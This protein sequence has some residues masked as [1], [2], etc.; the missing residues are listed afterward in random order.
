MVD[1]APTGHTLRLLAMPATLRRIA[2]VLDD[3]QAKHRFLAESLGGRHRADTADALMDEVDAAR[4]WIWPSCCGIPARARLVDHAAG[5]AGLAEAR[6]GIGALD[7]RDRREGGRR[8]PGDAAAAGTVRGVRGADRVPRSRS[9]R[10]ARAS[11]QAPLRAA[12][13]RSG[14][15][16]GPVLLRHV[17][18]DPGGR[19]ARRRPRPPAR[20]AASR[21]ARGTRS[22]G[23]DDWL[24]VLAP[25]GV[26]LILFAGKGGVGKTT[27]AAAVA[28]ALAGRAPARVCCCCPPIPRTRSVMCSPPRSTTRRGPCR[29]R[30]PR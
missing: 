26:R 28:L 7:G 14:E 3:M 18:R 15:P 13:A 25:P 2:A 11:R 6:D 5:S 20:G 23:G 21:D 8:Q 4:P 29:A 1:T 24:S 30:R 12:A 9:W 16:R 10:A 27:C 22:R 19:R 17:G